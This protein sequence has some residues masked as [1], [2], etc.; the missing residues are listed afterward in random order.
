MR[1]RRIQSSSSL[2]LQLLF[3][4]FGLGA[5]SDNGIAKTVGSLVDG[6]WVMKR[7]RAGCDVMSAEDE[8]ERVMRGDAE[9]IGAFA[10]SG[11]KARG[12]VRDVR[13]ELCSRCA[14]AARSSAV[15]LRPRCKSDGR[16]RRVGVRD[17]RWRRSAGPA[18]SGEAGVMVRTTELSAD[19]GFSGMAEGQRMSLACSRSAHVKKP[20][21]V[22]QRNLV[23]QNFAA[24]SRVAWCD[25]RRHR[26]LTARPKSPSSPYA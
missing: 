21:L 6:T 23:W 3:A 14:P 25:P 5:V 15:K 4:G 19:A 18:A 9:R 11:T 8:A 20:C 2:S 1:F 22:D 13:G 24:K 26:H 17:E 7:S 12:D 10:L 16:A